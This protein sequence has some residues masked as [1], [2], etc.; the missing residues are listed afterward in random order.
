M[1]TVV[2]QLRAWQAMGGPELWTKAWDHTVLLV[3]GPLDGRSIT[4]DGGVIAE[5]AAGLALAFYLLAAQ[6]GVAPAEVTDEQVQALYADDVTADERQVNWERRLAV[7]GHDL[8]DTGD[9]VVHVWRIISH[10]HQ[11]PPGSYD[12]TL[13]F[14]MT[15]WGRGY[16]AG[17]VK[18]RG[19]GIS[20]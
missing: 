9:P 13:D 7:L 16:T 3:E 14:S 20:L 2:D 18:L 8:A 12:D 6:H 11:T 17:M 15:R 10:N 4:V 5:G 1:T 19:I